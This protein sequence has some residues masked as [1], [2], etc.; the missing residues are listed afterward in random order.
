[1]AWVHA[2]PKKNPGEENR[3]GPQAGRPRGGAEPGRNGHGWDVIPIKITAHKTISPFS[4]EKVMLRGGDWDAA[5]N[6]YADEPNHPNDNNLIIVRRG[7]GYFLFLWYCVL[8]TRRDDHDN[9]STIGSAVPIL[10]KQ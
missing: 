2:G 3:P 10:R 7:P 5:D 6:E 1:M 8:L 9:Q 4:S